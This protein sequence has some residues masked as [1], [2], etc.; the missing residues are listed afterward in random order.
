ML[1]QLS[2]NK[3]QMH[4]ARQSRDHRFDGLFY[5]GVLS[6]GIFCRP[7]CPAKLAKEENVQYYLSAALAIEAGFRPCKLCKPDIAPINSSLPSINPLIDNGIILIHKDLGLSIKDIAAQLGVS[8]RHLHQQFQQKMGLSPSSYQLSAKLLFAKQLLQ[9]S[10]YS[11]LEVAIASGFNSSRAMQYAFKNTFSM[12]PSSLR[13]S[14]KDKIPLETKLFIAYRPPYLWHALRDFLA[15]RQLPNVDQVTENSYTRWFEIDGYQ[16]KVIAIHNP[17]RSGF[18][19]FICVQHS[20]HIKPCLDQMTRILDCS[21]DWLSIADGIKKSGYTLTESTEGLRLPGT[22]NCFEAGCRAILGQ[23]VSVAGAVT[24]T[25]EF[26]QAIRKIHSGIGFPAP[27]QVTQETLCDVGMP[28]SRKSTLLLF[29]EFMS[30]E[31]NQEQIEKGDVSQLLTLKGIGPWTCQYILMRGVSHPDI[32]MEKDLGIIRQCEQN[33]LEPHKAKPWGSYLTLC[34][35]HDY[36]N[37]Q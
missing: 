33:N 8:T 1:A 6:T 23:Q 17:A 7:I 19:L 15:S 31:K 21:A 16:G 20:T 30:E 13:K 4:K 18:D 29:A 12:S 14:D 10:H 11:I 9:H 22:W 35:W 24:K 5:I 2:L 25:R 32:W 27:W 28:I 34:L 37:K 3:E 36:M 26:V